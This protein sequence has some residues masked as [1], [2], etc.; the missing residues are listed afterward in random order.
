MNFSSFIDLRVVARRAMAEYG[1]WSEFPAPVAHEVADLKEKDPE[2]VPNGKVRD[3]RDLLWSSIDNVDSKDLDQLEFCERRQNREIR[4]MVAIADVDGYVPKGCKTD[5]HARYNGTS[6]YTGVEVFPMLPDRLS[7]DLSSLVP[8]GER[9]AVIVE[10]FVLKDGSVRSGDV[11]QARVSNKAKLVY[12]SVG[13]WLEG[14]GPVPE[15]AKSIPGLEEQLLLQDEA[16]QRLHEFRMGNGA[17]ELETIE[18]TPVMKGDEVADLVLKKKNPARLIVENF[19]VA[20]NSTMVRFLEKHDCPYIQRIVRTP[21]RWPRIRQI[22]LELGEELPADPDSKALSDFLAR[23]RHAD[24]K[25]FPDLS[26]TIVKLIGAGEYVMAEPGRPKE[27]HFGLAVHDYTHSTAPN[28]RYVDLIVQRLIKAVLSGENMPYT[29]TELAEIAGWCT[30]RDKSSK[31]VERFMRK[32]AG[33]ML[34]RG[35]IGQEFDALVT[36]ASD[37][38]TYVRLLSPPVE[39]RVMRNEK[40]MEIGQSVRVKLIAMEPEKGYIDFEGVTV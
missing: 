6:V 9:F 20:A 15:L 36:G 14:A 5:D 27:G 24:L 3:L 25:H 26:L 22:A 18:V 1:F 31:K 37:K 2:A 39:G 32:V 11:F 21:E 7:A 38:G 35:K 33:A 34:L 29:K 10:Y 40:G 13:E 30:D 8:D 16:S 4:V 17:L 12:E 28:R 23:Q 19:M